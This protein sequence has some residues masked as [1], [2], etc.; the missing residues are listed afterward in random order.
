MSGLRRLTGFSAALA[1]LALLGCEAPKIDFSTIQRP[2]RPAELDAFDV[3]VGDWTWEADVENAEGPDKHWTGTAKW[4][5]TLDNRCLHGLLSAKTAN[6]SFN[7]AGIWSW[8]PRD[9]E[10]IWWMF[11]DWGFP[12]QGTARYDKANQSWDMTFK[13]VGLDGTPSYGRYTMKVVDHNTL[14]WTLEEHADMGRT[15]MPKMKMKGTYKRRA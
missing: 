1:G 14:E 7:A 9:K 10:Y 13:S 6:A 5:W 8:H 2:A 11:N 15:M 4:E 3:F 12:Q